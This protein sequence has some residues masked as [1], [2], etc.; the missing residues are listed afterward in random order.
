MKNQF[1]RPDLVILDR[2]LSGMDGLKICQ[3]LKNNEATRSI[4]VI[5]MSATSHLSNIVKNTSADDYL[6]K[7]FNIKELLAKIDKYLG[8]VSV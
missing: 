2:Q 3:H 4:P 7:P 5:I 6:E 1:E 8:G